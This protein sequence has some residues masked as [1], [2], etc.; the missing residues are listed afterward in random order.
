VGLGDGYSS[1]GDLELKEYTT[2][3]RQYGI[4]RNKRP[5]TMAGME[6][7]DVVEGRELDQVVCFAKDERTRFQFC[8]RTRVPTT[9]S[10]IIFDFNININ[11][12][13]NSFQGLPNPHTSIAIKSRNENTH[14]WN[15]VSNLNISFHRKLTLLVQS[16]SIFLEC[17][18]RNSLSRAIRQ[19]GPPS[20]PLLEVADAGAWIVR[21][22]FEFANGYA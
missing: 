21:H 12:N 1:G 9:N 18:Q 2:I 5:Q 7:N 3:S 19:H 20:L 8:S 17:T 13:P 11:V 6:Q 16:H 10:E 4:N 22:I 15:T 14:S